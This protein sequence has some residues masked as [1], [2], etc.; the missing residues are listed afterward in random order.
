MKPELWHPP[1][2]LSDSEQEI[3]S[4][5]RRAKLIRSFCFVVGIAKKSPIGSRV[6]PYNAHPTIGALPRF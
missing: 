3:V 5:I 4:R 2:E 1:L 6:F